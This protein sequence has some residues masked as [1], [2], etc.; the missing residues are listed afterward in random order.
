ML[1]A[2]NPKDLVLTDRLQFDQLL[3]FFPSRPTVTILIVVDTSISFTSSFGVG[4][5]IDLIR[6]NVDGYVTFEVELARLGTEGSTLMVDATPA[7]KQP[8]YDNFRFSSQVAG[9]YVIDEYDEIW[10]F[11]FAPGNDGSPNDDNIWNNPYASTDED[12]AVLTQWMNAGGGMLAMG[13]HH[14]LGASMCAKIPRVRSMR[15]WTNA[16]NVPP[17]GELERFDTNRPQNSL[18][19]PNI[20]PNPAVIPN[21]AESDGVPQP[22]EWKRYPVPSGFVFERRYRPHPILC[23]GDL[24]VIDVFPDHPHEGWVYEDA[25]IDLSATYSFGDISGDEYPTLDSMQAQPETVAWANT[26][27]DPPYNFAK[28]DSPAKRFAVLGTYDGDQSG[29]GRVVVDSTWHHWLDLN[30]VGLESESPNTE[31]QKIVR[32]YRNCAVWLAREGQRRR[33]LVYATFWSTLFAPAFEDFMEGETILTLGS[34]AIDIIGRMT[35]EC[36]VRDWINIVIP[37]SLIAGLNPPLPLPDPSPFRSD[38]SV[39]IVQR[40]VL[41]GMVKEMIPL[42]DE[43]SRLHVDPKAKLN[44]LS[45]DAIFDSAGR[46]AQKG[47]E[48]FHISMKKNL[49]IFE[50]LTR[51]ENLPIKDEKPREML[52]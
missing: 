22:I 29:V 20:T 14:Y 11:G 48:Q 37:D 46:G 42:R 49:K 43:L 25:E 47:L 21:M 33:M 40:S 15:R 27:P 8:K 19:D 36:L 13:D 38:S 6:S 5:V 23:G 51:F 50:E 2:F 24:G 17:I 4:Q 35:S 39:E 41:G 16:Q 26:L 52:S 9:Q 10:C 28:G 1:N 34:K 31:Y 30:I 32:Y 12:L 45:G 3:P 7:P 18:Q 44:N